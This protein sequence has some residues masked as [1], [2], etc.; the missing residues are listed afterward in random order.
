LPIGLLQSALLPAELTRL[1]I[2][3]RRQRGYAP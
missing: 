3:L 2:T 1:G